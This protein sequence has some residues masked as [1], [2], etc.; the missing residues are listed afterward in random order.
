MTR[1]AASVLAAL[2]VG[3]VVLAAAEHGNMDAAG[4][5]AKFKTELNLNTDQA[6]RVESVF[7]DM[8]E[9]MGA[10][11]TRRGAV[12]DELVALRGGGDAAAITAKESEMKAF[13]SES[14]ALIAERDA[15]LKG[16]LTA[17][18]FAG[19]KELAA[20]RAKTGMAGSHG[21]GGHGGGHGGG[22][23]GGQG[24]PR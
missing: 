4:H 14:H 1:K 6:A 9:T 5:A 22:G 18:Q 3:L 20:A 17:K 8:S 13:G 19:F 23:H 2:C 15:A 10:I 21:G 24:H 16:I 7:A 12:H 11:Q